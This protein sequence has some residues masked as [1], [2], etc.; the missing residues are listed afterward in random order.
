MTW[1]L[2]G[3]ASSPPPVSV[4]R[5]PAKP[6]LQKSAAP[7]P[8]SCSKQVQNDSDELMVLQRNCGRVIVVRS[9][10]DLLDEH[11]GWGKAENVEGIVLRW[12]N[13]VCYELVC[14]LR[15]VRSMMP[16]LGAKNPSA[17]PSFGHFTS[18]TLR[19]CIGEYAGR[20]DGAQAAVLSRCSDVGS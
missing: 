11:G 13:G 16:S 20:G 10:V 14:G 19:T 2:H 17:M 4:V 8:H 9:R 7:L 18:N 12:E 6:S 1:G 3:Q 5:R 15:C